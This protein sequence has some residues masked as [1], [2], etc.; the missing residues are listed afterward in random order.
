[1]TYGTFSP[2]AQGEPYP[3]FE[4]LKDDFA[5]MREAGINT[6]RLYTPPS[7]RIADAA[8]D[9]GLFLIPD[10]CWGPRFCEF[11]KTDDLNA[12]YDW[13]R[14]HTRR[15]ANHP[16]MLMFSIGNEIP[17]LIVRWYGR[18]ET[19]NF[20]HRLSDIVKEESPG[21]LVTYAWHPP[22]EHLHL[23]FL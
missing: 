15:L 4:K 5:Q 6:V 19:E 10:I 8:A 16:A 23:P 9:M 21:A 7:D 1:V 13:T 3:E 11:H 14:S 20:L 17:P 18:R 2:N 22:T 12:I